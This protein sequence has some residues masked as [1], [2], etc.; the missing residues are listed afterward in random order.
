[1]RSS[2]SIEPLGLDFTSTTSR[3]ATIADAG[4][5]PCA[6]SGTMTLVRLVSPPRDV[7]LTHH[8]QTGK[9]SMGSGIGIERELLR[10]PQART[11]PAADCSR[12]R[13]RPARSLLPE[14][15]G[16]RRIPGIA[17]TSSLILGLYFMV[18]LPRG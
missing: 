7:I 18:Q 3:P 12:V 6:V 5:V 13:A 14:A 1:M 17:A 2:T 11:E 15:D 8:H 16:F 9:L 4:L 10:D